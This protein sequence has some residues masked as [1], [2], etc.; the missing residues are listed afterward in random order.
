IEVG[1]VLQRPRVPHK[2]TFESVIACPLSATRD[3]TS[4]RLTHR[5]VDMRKVVI[6][7]VALLIAGMLAGNA[8]AA[9]LTGCCHRAG[10]WMCGM[11]C[12]G[13]LRKRL[14]RG[15]A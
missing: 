7:A 11:A 3:C 8:Q 15:V 5:E 13:V 6:G 2:R 12:G 10:A 1:R 9:P 14:L 4:L